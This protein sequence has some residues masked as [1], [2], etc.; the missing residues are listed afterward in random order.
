[1]TNKAT[2]GIFLPWLLPR[3]HLKYYFSQN[4]VTDPPSSPLIVG[5][6]RKEAVLQ[7]LATQ[8]FN[9]IKSRIFVGALGLVG[10]IDGIV[11]IIGGALLSATSPKSPEPFYLVSSGGL[12]TTLSFA[13]MVLGLGINKRGLDRIHLIRE[14]WIRRKLQ[15]I[16]LDQLPP[17]GLPEESATPLAAVTAQE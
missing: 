16:P 2:G 11:R 9:I 17:A 14:R 3:Q 1:M 5:L 15:Q 13:V 10:G 4:Q 7:N 6:G 8:R 12:E